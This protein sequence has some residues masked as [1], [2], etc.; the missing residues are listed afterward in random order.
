MTINKILLIGG[1]GFIGIHTAKILES[2]G[3]EVALVDNF[4]SSE[5]DEL[6]KKFRLYQIDASDLLALRSAYQDFTPDIVYVF[7][8]VV[9]VPVTI[10]NPLTV[11]SGILSLMNACELNMDYG[12]KYTIY[13]SSGYVYGNKNP[14]P[15]TERT[16]LDPVNPYNISKIFC[17]NFLDFYSQKYG[18]DSAI[19]R[20]APTYGPRRKI[21][22]IIDFI[23]KALNGEQVTLYGSVTRDYVYVEDVA[24]A[25]L[26]VLK[27]MSKGS[28]LYNIGTGIEFTMEQVYWTICEIL[29]CK[30]RDIIQNNS[31]ASEINRFFLDC[32]KARLELDFKFEHSLRDGLSKT[33]AWMQVRK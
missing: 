14:L 23:G 12:V 24:L 8:S 27:H 26:Q 20:Y 5:C 4:S 33:I 11:K 29:N 15:Y 21:G 28:T 22:P 19:M 13:A 17:E 9:D 6:T 10:K 32:S 30:P 16:P 25:N 3:Y 2:S 31:N 7:S 1:A 18:L